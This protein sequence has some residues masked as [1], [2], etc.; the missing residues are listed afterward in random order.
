MPTTEQLAGQIKEIRDEE[1]APLMKDMEAVKRD[2]A[3][4]GSQASAMKGELASQIREI[5]DDVDPLTL[6]LR[7]LL[8]QFDAFR[9]Q[10]LSDRDVLRSDASRI[11]DDLRKLS[12]Q[13]GAFNSEIR[14]VVAVL[15]SDVDALNSD[16]P[17]SRKLRD[18]FTSFRTETRTLVG[19]AKWVGGILGSFLLGGAAAGVWWGGR[20]DSQVPDLARRVQQLESE[21]RKGHG[22][23]QIN[24]PPG[25]AKA[26]GAQSATP[27]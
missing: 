18:D 25:A 19:V 13:F 12:D 9:S 10:I 3:T 8:E 7:G 24:A 23:G 6:E 15:K 5:R 17:E 2:V 14:S 26:A 4:L 11:Q 27:K 1:L 16:V 20:I 22:P 21:S